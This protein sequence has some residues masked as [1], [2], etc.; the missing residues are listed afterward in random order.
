[1]R[2]NE[3]YEGQYGDWLKRVNGR[4]E[5][6]AGKGRGSGSIRGIVIEQGKEAQKDR[7]VIQREEAF[8]TPTQPKGGTVN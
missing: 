1:M 4:S 7:N 5:S 3:L 2:N 8:G 6:K